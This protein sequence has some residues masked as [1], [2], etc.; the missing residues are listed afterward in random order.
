MKND[1]ISDQRPDGD[2]SATITNLPLTDMV[3]QHRS[4]HR[5]GAR[6]APAESLGAAMGS[7]LDSAYGHGAN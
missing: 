6:E 4:R 7:G 3:G 5:A 1:N 2:N